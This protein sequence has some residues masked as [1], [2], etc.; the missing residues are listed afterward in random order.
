MLTTE[1][2][3]NISEG[4]KA[5]GERMT[6]LEEDTKTAFQELKTATDAL[7]HQA[8]MYGKAFLSG[9][10]ESGTEYRRF[11][12][13]EA[14]AKAFGELFLQAA[15][16]KALGEGTQTGGG[17]L[18]PEELLALIINKLG[19]Y[20]KFRRDATV[21]P[22][23]S[24]RTTLPK[25][26][27]DLTVYCPGEGNEIAES[28]MSFSQ[29]GMTA[30][31]WCCLTKVSSELEE[32]SVIGLGEILGLSISR[33]LAKKE[34]EVGFLGDGTSTYFGMTGI[35][36]ALRGV[37]A[38][39]GSIKGLQVGSSNAYSGLALVDFEGTVSILPSEADEGA[40]W[41]MSKKFYYQVP[42]ALARTAGVANIFE[43]LSDRKARY[44]YGY[45]VEFVHAMPSVEANSQICAI[46]G[47]LQLGSFL[48][49]RR[50]LTIARSTDVYFANDQ[51][52]FRGTERIDICAFGVGDTTEAGPIVGLITA[53]A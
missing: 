28:D 18:V 11:W 40:K 35:V 16:K 41:Y 2:K 25:V 7:T 8:K 48:G 26:D 46:L 19:Q 45:P 1:E 31:K 36:G 38:T 51:I 27:A 23:G 29:V 9:H 43:I 21:I 50:Q 20:G 4:F 49:E 13:T 17:V 39:I 37:D 12:P 42:Y 22:M 47:D 15:G 6:V 32:D 10:T 24:D 52:G 34:D 5:A 33:S 3:T 53:A 30:H 44:L 14:E